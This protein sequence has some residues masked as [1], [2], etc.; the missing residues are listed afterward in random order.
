MILEIKKLVPEAFHE[1]KCWNLSSE[2][3]LRGKVN[4]IHAVV[5][6]GDKKDTCVDAG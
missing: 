1:I 6:I 5:E 2:T 4:S 3:I